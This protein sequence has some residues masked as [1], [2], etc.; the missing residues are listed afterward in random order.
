VV[1]GEAVTQGDH[2]KVDS[3]QELEKKLPFILKRMEGWD[4]EVPM[5][6]K[7]EP[8]QNPR[9]L[10][11][12]AMS[13]IWYREIA[14]AMA[15]KGHKIDH[16]EPDEVWKLWLKK[17]F[18]GTASYSIGNQHIPEQVKSTILITSII[19]LP[20]R[21]FGYQYPQTASMPNYKPSRRHSE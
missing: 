16:E 7:L 19:G 10:S 20:S 11:Q 4:Y 2:V 6:V 9:S 3:S 17:R 13:H 5:V 1:T 12:N 18:L 21:A 15:D 14:N 8:Y